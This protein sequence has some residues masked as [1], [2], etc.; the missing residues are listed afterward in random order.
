MD[1]TNSLLIKAYLQVCESIVSIKADL[2]QTE[3][4]LT[5]RNADSP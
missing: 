1:P 5:K 3:Q 2:I 4:V